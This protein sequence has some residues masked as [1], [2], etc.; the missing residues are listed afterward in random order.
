M[1]S[2]RIQL[3]AAAIV[4]HSQYQYG[5]CR[6][7]LFSVSFF[8]QLKLVRSY[9]KKSVSV[10]IFVFFSFLLSLIFVISL[11]CLLV[12]QH[13]ICSLEYSYNLPTLESLIYLL[14]TTIFSFTL[15]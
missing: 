4:H 1:G 6:F 10:T 11:F 14:H 5:T 9:K 3:K 2:E 15:I 8:V 13:L 7:F 12:L